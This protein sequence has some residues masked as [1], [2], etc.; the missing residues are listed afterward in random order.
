M[1]TDNLS[2]YQQ[3]AASLSSGGF[4]DSTMTFSAGDD[5][6]LDRSSKGYLRGHERLYG[7]SL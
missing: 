5:D 3:Q 1:A 6:L 2:R 4:R 7:A